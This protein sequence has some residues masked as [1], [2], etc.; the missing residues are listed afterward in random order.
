[1]MGYH[2][3][4]GW[5]SWMVV[6]MW[7]WPLLVALAVWG[8]AVLTRGTTANPANAAEDPSEILKRRFA[9]GEMTADE[10]L[11]AGAILENGNRR[12]HG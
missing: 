1:M 10:Y 11:E 5:Q 8:L 2:A 6:A 4:N 9:R 7:I 3:S 12:A